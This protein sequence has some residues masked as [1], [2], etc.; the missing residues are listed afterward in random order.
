MLLM[1]SNSVQLKVERSIV[2]IMM[3]L[4]VS[5]QN[6]MGSTEKM[7]AQNP[8]EKVDLGD[9]SIKKQLTLAPRLTKTSKFKLLNC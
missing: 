2:F 5:K 3:N 6:P 9:G 1:I 7:R 4:W 8:M